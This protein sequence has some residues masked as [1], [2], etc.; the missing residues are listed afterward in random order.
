MKKLDER[1]EI[2]RVR[3]GEYNTKTT[4][5]CSPNDSSFC[6]DPPID[7][8]ISEIIV[9]HGYN[10]HSANSLDDIALLRLQKNVEYTRFI[11]AICLPFA[12]AILTHDY[13]NQQYLGIGWG[14]FFSMLNI[15]G[16]I[17]NLFSLQVKPMNHQ[18]AM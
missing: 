3:L 7:V 6:S 1:W 17:E 13:S 18:L 9:Y 2:E 12:P 15:K 5:D 4:V 16:K 10:K 11:Q 8:K 14:K